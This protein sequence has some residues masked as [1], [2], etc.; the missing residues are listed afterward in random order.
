MNEEH[1]EKEAPDENC[2]DVDIQPEEEL[3]TLG[4]AQAKLKK[5][6]DELAK[7]KAER[8]EFLDGWQRCKADSVNAR[9]ELLAQAERAS[10]RER[11]RLV[12]ELIPALDSFD[13]AAASEQWVSVDDGFRT[14]MEH[15]RSLIVETFANH[16]V[17]RF[18]KVG[19]QFDPALHEAAQEDKGAAGKEG[20]V[21]R[22]LRS[23][24]R[25]GERVMRPA[26]VIIKG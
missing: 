17:E 15:V 2:E 14:G 24:Y 21:I 13:M 9:K 22:V 4:A 3:G 25:T 8:Q 12:D 23:G 5:L 26:Q 7:A 11:D 6:K 10:A 1:Q 20:E 19:D 16:G 18:G